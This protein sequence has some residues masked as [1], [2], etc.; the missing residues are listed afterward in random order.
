MGGA[1][2]CKSTGDL[3]ATKEKYDRYGEVSESRASSRQIVVDRNKPRSML[4][5]ANTRLDNEKLE[6]EQYVSISFIF[7]H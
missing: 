1:W 2:S 3:A 5:Q 7:I 6:L 4:V